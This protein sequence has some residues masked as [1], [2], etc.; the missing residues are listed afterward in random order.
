MTASLSINIPEG[1]VLIDG[2]EVEE[3]EEEE[4]D[5]EV[6]EAIEVNI[7]IT[8]IA[9]ILFTF[10]EM[11]LRINEAQDILCL[12]IKEIHNNFSSPNKSVGTEVTMSYKTNYKITSLC[13]RINKNF[14][15][16]L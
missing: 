3:E 15:K 5:E 13:M 7:A 4:E 8:K 14:T 11:E 16:L 12:K 1:K 9:P 6:E 2:E 10:L